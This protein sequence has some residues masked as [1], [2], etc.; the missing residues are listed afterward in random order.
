MGNITITSDFGYS[1][2][3]AAELLGVLRQFFPNDNITE[4]TH[5]TTHGDIVQLTALVR[6]LYRYYP[7]GTIHLLAADEGYSAYHKGLLITYWQEQFW[8]APDNGTLFVLTENSRQ[9]THWIEPIQE[10]WPWLYAKAAQ[11]IYNNSKLTDIQLHK[12]PMVKL[13]PYPTTTKDSINGTVL[14]ADKQGNFI[15]NISRQEM[16]SVGK[17][18]PAKLFIRSAKQEIIYKSL[19]ETPNGNIYVGFGSNDLLKVCIRNGEAFK[20]LSAEKEDLF[21]IEFSPINDNPDKE[22]PKYN[23]SFSIEN[24]IHHIKP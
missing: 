7:T 14:Y 6:R 21:T 12:N 13:W 3:A 5:E 17:N 20:L 22:N 15:T 11:Q 8:V 23:L 1:G 2:T 19:F 4:V 10:H 18:R 24:E 9:P 16:E